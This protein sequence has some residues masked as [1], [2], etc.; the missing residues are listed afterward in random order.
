MLEVNNTAT[1]KEI[2]LAYKRLADKY[3]PDRIGQLEDDE[4]VDLHEKMKAINEAKSNLSDPVT[5]AKYD[6]RLGIDIDKDLRRLKSY[7]DEKELVQSSQPYQSNPYQSGYQGYGDNR[8]S[9]PA[10]TAPAS[11]SRTGSEYSTQSYSYGQ[12]D[13]Q[14]QTGYPQDGVEKETYM[15]PFCSKKFRMAPPTEIL[16]VTCPMC[17]RDI[18]IYPE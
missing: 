1:Y 3:H 15:C 12:L 11:Y 7:V 4:G 18:T 14:R 8:Y 13:D 6:K 10:S 9:A 5:R 16:V 17:S 2:K